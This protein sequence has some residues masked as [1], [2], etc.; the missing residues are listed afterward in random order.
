MFAAGD[1]DRVLL[2]GTKQAPSGRLTPEQF[3]TFA[4]GWLESAR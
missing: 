1:L 3:T 2:L 4:V